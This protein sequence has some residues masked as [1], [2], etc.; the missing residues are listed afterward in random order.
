MLE[1]CSRQL[2]WVIACFVLACFPVFGFGANDWITFS[3]L[4][5]KVHALQPWD[6][7]RLEAYPTHFPTVAQ[8]R[9]L[10]A[11][12]QQDAGIEGTEIS[13][14]PQRKTPP[15]SQLPPARPRCS[16]HRPGVLLCCERTESLN[17][18]MQAY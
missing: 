2:R 1:V 12:F 8:P 4:L 11:V 18:S 6:H 5:F 3:C 14:E 9:D 10:A 7:D 15:I 17:R 13:R 16:H